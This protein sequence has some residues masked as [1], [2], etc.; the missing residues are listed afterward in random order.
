MRKESKETH[1]IGMTTGSVEIEI[2]KAEVSSSV[3]TAEL[4]VE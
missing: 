1:E 4:T 3:T 2:P